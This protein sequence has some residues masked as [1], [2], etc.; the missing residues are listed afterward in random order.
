MHESDTDT[1]KDS[2]L[3]AKI[4][5]H[6]FPGSSNNFD[7]RQVK[8]QVIMT[9][10]VMTKTKMILKTGLSE[11]KYHYFCKIFHSSSSCKSPQKGQMPVSPYTLLSAIFSATS[12]KETTTD[13][14]KYVCE[15]INTAFSL[16]RK[17]KY[18]FESG[19]KIS[20]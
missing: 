11:T 4:H 9:V 20:H 2:G 1:I 17:K 15:R 14:T 10:V 8:M 13:N 18:F 16:G 12:F 3:D 6:D 19:G 7:V 5:W